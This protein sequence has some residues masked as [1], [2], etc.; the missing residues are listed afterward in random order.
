MAFNKNRGYRHKIISESSA[1]DVDFSVSVYR[2]S[3]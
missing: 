1:D 3:L 2:I